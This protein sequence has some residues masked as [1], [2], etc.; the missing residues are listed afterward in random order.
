MDLE[1]ELNDDDYESSDMKS[2][3]TPF[4]KETD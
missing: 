1:E 4:H 3:E 2:V